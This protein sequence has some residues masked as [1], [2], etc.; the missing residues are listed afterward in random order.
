VTTVGGKNAFRIGLF[1]SSAG[2]ARR[3][4]H[5]NIPRFLS[6]DSR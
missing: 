3:R 1:R 2:N 5:R 6:V 4:F